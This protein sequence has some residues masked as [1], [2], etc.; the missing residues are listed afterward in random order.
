[1]PW[2]ELYDPAADVW[3]AAAP[4]TVGRLGHTAT[5]LRDGRVLVAGGDL[6][7][8][9]SAE[10]YGNAPDD[11]D[12][13][14]PTLRVRDVTVPATSPS[15]ALVRTYPVSASDNLDPAPVI[16]CVPPAPQLLAPDSTTTVTCTA[17]DR[18]GNTAHRSFEIHVS[19]A[20]EQI[21]TLRTRLA[22][23][24]IPARA[25]RRLDRDLARALRAL[26]RDR[27]HRACARLHA[28]LRQVD[29]SA[30]HGTLSAT[31]AKGL[32][33]DGARIAGVAGC[34]PGKPPHW[35]R[36]AKPGV[37]GDMRGI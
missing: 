37:G 26:Q 8:G 28:F 36:S 17:T 25:Q 2:T 19:G 10:L 21:L 22:G 18:A 7:S 35:L 32:R 13:T 5:L 9:G 16:R 4:M 11:T 29:R 15:G 1:V 34:S 23:M 27:L 31:Q 3:R 12:T 20:A 14:A 24:A 30:R 33:A 6:S